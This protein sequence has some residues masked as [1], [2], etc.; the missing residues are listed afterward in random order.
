M[1]STIYIARERTWDVDAGTYLKA[2]EAADGQSLEPYVAQAINQFVLGCK[3]N[4]S[5]SAFKATCIMMGARTITG[6]LVPLAGPAPTALQG[7]A[8]SLYDRKTGIQANPGTGTFNYL[9]I[10]YRHETAPQSSRHLCWYVSQ[11]N[12]STAQ[13]SYGGSFGASTTGQGNSFMNTFTNSG[14]PQRLASRANSPGG[15]TATANQHV[16][17]GFYG[18]SRTNSANYIVRGSG[19][20]ETLT[21]AAPTPMPGDLGVFARISLPTDGGAAGEGNPAWISTGR[22]AFYS[23][24]EGLSMTPR[25]SRLTTL[26]NQIQTLIP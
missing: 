8:S 7:W 17:P 4:G 26:Y 14:A 2:V 10:N 3:A 24:G 20:D 15:V 18:V 23:F 11:I 5:F 13:Q 22:I 21:V 19:I 16:S 6:A 25:D 12:P 1:K 9:N